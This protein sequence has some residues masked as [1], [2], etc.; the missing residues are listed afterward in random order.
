LVDLPQAL[1][2][3]GAIVA[4]VKLHVSSFGLR[5]QLA[6]VFFADQQRFPILAKTKIALPPAP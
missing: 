4:E 5:W 6:Q 2:V 3:G 1:E